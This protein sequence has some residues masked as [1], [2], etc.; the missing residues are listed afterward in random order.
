MGPRTSIRGNTFRDVKETF[1]I[2]AS[3]G[4]RTSIRGN[5]TTSWIGDGSAPLQWGRGLPSAET[6][7]Q[8]RQ[9]FLD[10]W[11]QWGRGLPSAETRS[12]SQSWR[13]SCSLQW[14]RGLPSAET[15]HLAPLFA[16]RVLASMGPRTS[17][18]GNVVHTAL[19]VLCRHVSMGPR[20]SIRGNMLRPI[21]MANIDP[22]Q[23][24]RGL[25]SAETWSL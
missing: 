8:R 17:I 5:T 16:H 21:V 25:P 20:T 22:L 4:P 2:P 19:V 3:M 15:V 24:G 6:W 9:V 1:V 12:R 23:W 7:G 13:A 18:R 14:G 11:L 10:A